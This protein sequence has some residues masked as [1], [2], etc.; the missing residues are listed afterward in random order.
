MPSDS[1][2]SWRRST[3]S[4]AMIWYSSRIKPVLAP[5]Q[6]IAGGFLVEAERPT[7][8]SSAVPSVGA[9]TRHSPTCRGRAAGT[10][11]RTR[12]RNCPGPVRR[13]AA[14]SKSWQK[15]ASFNCRVGMPA[16][17]GSDAGIAEDAVDVAVVGLDETD[18]AGGGRRQDRGCR[19]PDGADARFVPAERMSLQRP[20]RPADL[21]G[22]DCTRAHC[23]LQENR[24]PPSI[25]SRPL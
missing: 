20:G 13:C 22:T 17:S 15:A 24:P 23:A 3:I 9:E 5:T 10:G 18:D 7:R 2:A 11:C 1:S 14:S 19:G 16:M 6:R 12:G 8:L 21:A 4:G 25:M